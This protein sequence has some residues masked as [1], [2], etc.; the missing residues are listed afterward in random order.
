MMRALALLMSLLLAACGFHLRGQAGMPFGTLYLKVPANTAFIAEL[1]RNLEAN[2]VR[3]VGSAD[4]AEI[5]LDI[6]QE[7]PEKQILS[8][9]GSGRVSEYS[10]RYR[11]TLRAYDRELRDWIPATDI[12]LRRDYSYDDTRILAKEAEESLLYQS[13]RN[14]M[15]QQIIRR[16]SHSRP[17]PQS[18]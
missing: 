5:V 10:L 18:P 9:G 6:M 7:F 8:L 15:V 16:L 13:M 3:L 1:R 11:V 4:Q 14:D 17:Q 12:V 2:N